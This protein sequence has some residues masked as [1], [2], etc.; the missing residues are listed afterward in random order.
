MDGCQL[1]EYGNGF[2][3][4]QKQLMYMFLLK[5]QPIEK[6]KKFLNE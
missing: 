3:Q 2:S 1:R 5:E 6:L 4:Y